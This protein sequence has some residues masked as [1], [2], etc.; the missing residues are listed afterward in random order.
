MQI[1]ARECGLAGQNEGH[2]ECLLQEAA[3]SEDSPL[4]QVRWTTKTG[5]SVSVGV[6]SF[7]KY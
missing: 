7:G 5:V 6:A 4:Y 2:L 1:L 3:G